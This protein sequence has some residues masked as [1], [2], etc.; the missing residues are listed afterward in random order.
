[1]Q[2]LPSPIYTGSNA[3]ESEGSIDVDVSP[4]PSF[5]AKN[6]KLEPGHSMDI[7]AEEGDGKESGNREE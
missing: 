4:L 6:S 7:H 2:D 3:S 5:S 1:M